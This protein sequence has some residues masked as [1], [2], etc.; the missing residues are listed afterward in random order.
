MAS[1]TDRFID[2]K[3]SA[4]INPKDGFVVSKCKE[5]R[6]R[7]VLE[8]LVPLLY[9][10]KPTRVT[11]TVENTIFGALYGKRPI[12][13]GQVVKDVVQRL[14]AEMSKSKATPI[15]PFIFHI[16]HIHEVLLSA[17]KK[18]YRIAKALLKHNVE[19]EEEENPEDSEDSDPESLSS[20]ETQEI[21]RQEFAR[22][23]KSSS[24]KRVSPIAKDLVAKLKTPTPLEGPDRNYQVIAHN[25]KEIQE[26]KHA[27]GELIRALCKKLKNVKPEG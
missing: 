17:E 12:G 14:F 21:Q 18:E 26:R 2:G 9:L 25:L 15:C 7:R 27:Q 3:F 4:R 10:E 24:N 5:A 20:K 19:L 6:A 13:W 8:F 11:I 22:L 1:R 23:K 16:Y